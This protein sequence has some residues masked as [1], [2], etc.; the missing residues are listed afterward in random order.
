MELDIKERSIGCLT[1]AMWFLMVFCAGLIL[2]CLG[3]CKSVKYV[4]YETIKH[5]SIYISK[6]DTVK[7]THTI[8][9]KEYVEVKDSASTTLDEQG[10]ILKQ[11]IWHN[12]TIIRQMS[13]S[14]DYYRAMYDSLR[15]VSQDTIRIPI[16]IERELSNAEK[17]Y[18]SIGKVSL[19]LYIGLLIAL[20][21]WLVYYVKCK[22]KLP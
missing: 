6:T 17:R 7:L 20:I 14:L 5:D 9:E 13:D 8:K 10:N 16:P 4:P 12:K 2:I 1:L 22:K 11:E 15:A 19:G 21:A 18:I 3:S